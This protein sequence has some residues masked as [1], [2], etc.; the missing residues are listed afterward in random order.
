VA[1]VSHEAEVSHHL[2]RAAA[3]VWPVIVMRTVEFVH[4]VE[5]SELFFNES[6]VS[7]FSNHRSSRLGHTLRTRFSKAKVIRLSDFLKRE[8]SLR[9]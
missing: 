4:E 8:P 7:D 5:E 1:S 2:D 6:L 3:W 9:R